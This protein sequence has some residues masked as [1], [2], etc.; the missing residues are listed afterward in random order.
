MNPIGEIAIP[1]KLSA[2]ITAKVNSRDCVKWR[3][4]VKNWGESF[5]HYRGSV[6]M[7]LRRTG[8]DK[9]GSWMIKTD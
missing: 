2:V 3:G 4:R 7:L 6:L 9:V 8:I 5:F 1:R